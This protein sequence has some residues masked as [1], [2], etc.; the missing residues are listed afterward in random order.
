[1]KTPPKHQWRDGGPTTH[2]SSA[3]HVPIDTGAQANHAHANFQLNAA[4][5]AS[6][7][8][9]HLPLVPAARSLARPSIYALLSTWMLECHARIQEW[10]GG[11]SGAAALVDFVERPHT[12]RVRRARQQLEDGWQRGQRHA[13]TAEPTVTSP[14][15]AAT[16]PLHAAHATPA[17]G[18]GAGSTTGVQQPPPPPPPTTEAPSRWWLPLPLPGVRSLVNRGAVGDRLRVGVGAA[19]AVRSALTGLGRARLSARMPP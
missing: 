12:Q 19:G 16:A 1:M 2:T 18:D 14:P 17:K 8:P 15:T 5:A 9:M 7:A 3:H 10:P 6:D 4:A 11:S 13:V